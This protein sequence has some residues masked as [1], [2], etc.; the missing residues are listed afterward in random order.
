MDNIVVI[1]N[2]EPRVSSYFIA[3]GFNKSHK[4]VWNAI[5]RFRPRLE[6]FGVIPHRKEKLQNPD[7]DGKGK[8]G[9][10][11]N[12]YMLNEEQ[13]IFLI[14]LFQNSEIVLD[15]KEKLVRGF[16]Q[17]RRLLERVVENQYDPSWVQKRL[18]GKTRR[19]EETDA[20][21]DFVTYAE[22]QG[23]KNA[24]W[25]Y[26]IFTRMENEALFIIE[27][28]F[29]NLRDMMTGTQLMTIGVAD[30]IVA[31]T[32][33]EGMASRLYYRDIYQKA[34]ENMIA[35]AK[36]HGQEKI[37]VEIKMLEDKKEG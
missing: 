18:E 19:F 17:Q 34:K 21:K 24:G 35:F 1:Y 33:Q 32:I 13:A 8:G 23:S 26:K 11:V 16:C 9:R 30:K 7:T 6:R 15:F 27:G 25:Y 4:A 31:K 12:A 20:I 2:N 14:T 3:K 29:K 10:P 36:L 28:K 22:K 37:I 5:D